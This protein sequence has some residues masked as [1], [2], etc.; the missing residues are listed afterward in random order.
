[1]GRALNRLAHGRN[2]YPFGVVSYPKSGRTWLRVM[3]DELGVDAD[4]THNSPRDKSKL[5]F[6]QLTTRTERT[7]GKILVLVRDPRDTLVSAFHQSTKRADEFSGGITDYVRSPFFGIE[8]IARFNLLWTQYAIEHRNAAVTTYEWL[9]ADTIGEMAR[10]LQF[11]G[12]RAPRDRVAAV[13]AKNEF[14]KMQERERSGELAKRYGSI[15]APADPSDPSTFKVRRGIVGGHK[16]ELSSDDL[17][18]VNDVLDRLDYA[19]R[20]KALLPQR[21]A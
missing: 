14:K 18:Y 13:V 3:F 19:K 10:L 4:F 5:S 8:K 11:F 9:R 1:M 6:D 21:E 17:A 20:M 7:Y 15:V 16:E 2:W 12:R